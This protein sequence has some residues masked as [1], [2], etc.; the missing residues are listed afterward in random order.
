MSLDLTV[1]QCGEEG[2]GLT[3]L[4]SAELPGQGMHE[5]EPAVSL[6]QNCAGHFLCGMPF[7][8]G[9]RAAYQIGSGLI[10][11]NTYEEVQGCLLC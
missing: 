4:G 6:S 8:A 11:G 5:L 3:F 1:E 7:Q 2:S 10:L 9:K